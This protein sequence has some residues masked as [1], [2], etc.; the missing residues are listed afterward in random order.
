MEKFL[1]V[2]PTVGVANRITTYRSPRNPKQ[3]ASRSHGGFDQ[4]EASMNTMLALVLGGE[5]TRRFK[6]PDLD[7]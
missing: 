4:D 2:L 6:A 3:S 5:P 7:D 1:A